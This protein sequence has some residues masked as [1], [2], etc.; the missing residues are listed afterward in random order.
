MAYIQGIPREQVIMFPECV[1]D[2][3]GEENLVRFIDVFVDSL[4]L[5][6]LAFVHSVPN[7]KGRPP[8]HPAA[9][10]KL[11]VYGYVNRIRSSRCIEREARRNIEVMWL[12]QKLTPDF[13]T[14]ADFRRDNGV[15]IKQVCIEF[16][17]LCK[18]LGLLGGE[19]ISVDSAKFRAVN[20]KKRNF[21]RAKLEKA[22]EEIGEKV[23]GYMA[24]LEDNDKVE[25]DL[26][27]GNGEHIKEKIEALKRR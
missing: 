18:R 22:I 13:K 10:L 20:S 26:P 3:V 23:E 11:Y 19:L 8:Y 5:A 21:N 14:I 7:D 1:D 9:M 2:Y 15:A 17:V 12:M 27:C 16:T 24:E 6:G 4:D 25:A